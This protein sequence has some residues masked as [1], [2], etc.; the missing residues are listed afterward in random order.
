MIFVFF[1]ES[2]PPVLKYGQILVVNKKDLCKQFIQTFIS[3]RGIQM[4]HLRKLVQHLHLANYYN[5]MIIEGP[6]RYITQLT[7]STHPWGRLDLCPLCCQTLHHSITTKPVSEGTQELKAKKMLNYTVSNSNIP[8][9]AS[10]CD[11]LNSNLAHFSVLV[12]LVVQCRPLAYS[13]L[14]D[15]FRSLLPPSLVAVCFSPPLG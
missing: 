9:A 11:G 2:W 6:S 5:K 3:L 15:L 14:E 7:S 1:A 10:H 12:P 13:P 8:S 4:T